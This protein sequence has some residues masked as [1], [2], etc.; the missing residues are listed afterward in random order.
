[1]ICRPVYRII[2]SSHIQLLFIFLLKETFVNPYLRSKTEGMHLSFV[3][4]IYVRLPYFIVGLLGVIGFVSSITVF[5]LNSKI[6]RA[7]CITKIRNYCLL[8]DECQHTGRIE[9][10]KPNEQPPTPNL[11]RTVKILQPSV[12]QF[13]SLSNWDTLDCSDAL[14][15]NLTHIIKLQ[16]P[17]CVKQHFLLT[18]GAFT[19]CPKHSFDD[20]KQSFEDG[21]QSFMTS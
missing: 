7:F 17:S 6:D 16:S 2:R 19:S 21:R 15:S 9:P 14:T 18:S 20:E 13:S 5:L 11:T 12:Y 3:R 10:Q 1:M 4:N 8:V